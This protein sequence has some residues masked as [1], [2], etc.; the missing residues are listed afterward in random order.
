M[1]KEREIEARVRMPQLI[2]SASCTLIIHVNPSLSHS[3]RSH[4]IPY[5]FVCG[6]HQFESAVHIVRITLV[7]S[8][9]QSIFVITKYLIER[10]KKKQLKVN[11]KRLQKKILVKI[12]NKKKTLKLQRELKT[13]FTSNLFLIYS[14]TTFLQFSLIKLLLTFILLLCQKLPYE[15]NKQLKSKENTR[16]IQLQVLN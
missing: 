13:L 9:V 15:F 12:I 4:F 11:Q 6:Q 8:C 7:F 14:I 2:A 16:R 1:E 10:R 3:I 5:I